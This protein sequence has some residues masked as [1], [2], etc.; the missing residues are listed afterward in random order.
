MEYNNIVRVVATSN[1]K[2][3]NRMLEAG[4]VLLSSGFCRGEVPGYDYHSYSL[5]LPKDVAASIGDDE[6][7]DDYGF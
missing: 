2:E 3:A 6:D 7:E 5:G 1:E 4:W